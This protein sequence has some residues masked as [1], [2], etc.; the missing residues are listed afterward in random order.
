MKRGLIYLIATINGV[1]VLILNVAVQ[2]MS[3][4]K[5]QQMTNNEIS[6]TRKYQQQ[7]QQKAVPSISLREALSTILG[8]EREKYIQLYCLLEMAYNLGYGD[9]MRRI[10]TGNPK[11]SEYQLEHILKG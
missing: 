9:G 1:G 10:H 4:K 3:N 7:Y 6:I 11:I 2:I 5:D 8:E